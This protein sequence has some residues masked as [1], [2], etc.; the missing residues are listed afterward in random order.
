MQ[1]KKGTP[2]A[3]PIQAQLS[4]ISYSYQLPKKITQAALMEHIP[5]L[6]RLKQANQSMHTSIVHHNGIFVVVVIHENYC[7]CECHW[8]LSEAGAAMTLGLLDRANKFK[9]FIEPYD[10]F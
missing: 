8:N 2:K 6:Y 5:M 1:T 10:L 7:F 9:N 4:P 3:Q